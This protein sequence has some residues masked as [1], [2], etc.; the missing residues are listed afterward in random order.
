MTDCRRFTFYRLR[1]GNFIHF[2]W[3][4]RRSIVQLYTS[5]GKTRTTVDASRL[6]KKINKYLFHV[7]HIINNWC[8]TWQQNRM[9]ASKKYL[10]ENR[11][12]WFFERKFTIL[13]SIFLKPFW[14]NEKYTKNQKH[15]LFQKKKK[16]GTWVYKYKVKILQFS[17][18]K[19]FSQLDNDKLESYQFQ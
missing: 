7:T 15:V 17:F 16:N 11:P 6:K 2:F 14:L 13:Y 5:S 3:I 4:L 12:F 10:W 18:F 8:F 9:Y 1:S 19:I